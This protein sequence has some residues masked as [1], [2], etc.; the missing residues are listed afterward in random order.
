MNLR[1]AFFLF[2]GGLMAGMWLR[3]VLQPLRQLPVRVD[4]QRVEL[5]N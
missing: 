4:C 1:A 5:L 2:M 3:D